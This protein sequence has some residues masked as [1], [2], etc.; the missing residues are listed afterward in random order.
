[1]RRFIVGAHHHHRAATSAIRSQ[2]RA[3]ASVATL[4]SVQQALCGAMGPDVAAKVTPEMALEYGQFYKIPATTTTSTTTTPCQP[5]PTATTKP[6]GIVQGLVEHQSL[7]TARLR[8]EEADL[9]TTTASIAKLHGG[10][11]PDG[12][13]AAISASSLD[14]IPIFLVHYTQV[15]PTATASNGEVKETAAEATDD[16]K[17]VA[18]FYFPQQGKVVFRDC[19]Q[20]PP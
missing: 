12:Q 6:G 20:D 7:L 17:Y 2:K 13:S 9:K 4:A 5:P 11:D 18:H 14:P 8:D 15:Q 16:G 19:R 1:M 3:I 10:S